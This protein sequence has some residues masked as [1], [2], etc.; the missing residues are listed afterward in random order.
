[1]ALEIKEKFEVVDSETDIERLIT[2]APKEVA[3]T[4]AQKSVIILPSHESADSFYHGTL[5]TLDYL[6]DHGLST[7]VYSNDDEYKELSLH[8]ADIWLGTFFI[9]NFVIPV[10]CSVIAAYIYEKLRAKKDDKISLKFIVEKKDGNTTT[11]SYDGEVDNL[12]KA[13]DSVKSLSDED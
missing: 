5:E 6:N 8:G 4:I 11:V 1:M 10:F 13:I 3:E 7:D 9:K 2:D 12:D